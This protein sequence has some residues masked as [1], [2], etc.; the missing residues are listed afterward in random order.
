M[1]I[2][3]IF[4]GSKK[5]MENKVKS[6]FSDPP[7]LE[8]E[9]LILCKITEEHT[10]VF[11]KKNMPTAHSMTGVLSTRKPGSLSAPAVTHLSILMKRLPKWDMY[12]QNRSGDRVL[13]QRL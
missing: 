8:T 9:R 13:Q 10:Y 12:L 11:F 7:V 4:N 2:F 6:T 3:N 5:D 1:S